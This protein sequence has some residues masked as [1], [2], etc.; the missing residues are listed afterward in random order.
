MIQLWF[1]L[2]L[3]SIGKVTIKTFL[4]LWYCPFVLFYPYIPTQTLRKIKWPSAISRLTAHFA[5]GLMSDLGIRKHR[6]EYGH[7]WYWMSSLR[8]G[9][10]KQHTLRTHASVNSFL[11]HAWWQSNSRCS[12]NAVHSRTRWSG[13]KIETELLHQAV[14]SSLECRSHC[15]RNDWPYRR[16]VPQETIP[17]RTLFKISISYAPKCLLIWGWKLLGSWSL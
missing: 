12:R 1:M 2:W 14:S 7:L 13:K 17:E 3:A 9:V 11:P 15:S 4:L 6:K 16:A 8:P 10:I 5:C